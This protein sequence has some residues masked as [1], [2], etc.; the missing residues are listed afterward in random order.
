MPPALA[1]TLIS[2][3]V[4]LLYRGNLAP[5]MRGATFGALILILFNVGRLVAYEV[6]GGYQS[7]D[8]SNS[9]GAASSLP[10]GVEALPDIYYLIF[11]GYSSA[12]VL[13]E[14]H[15]FDNSEFIRSL[16]RKGFYIPPDARSNY[17]TTPLS[18]AS[19][20]RMKYLHPSIPTLYRIDDNEVLNFVKSVGYQYI[21]LDSGH[22]YTRRNPY[23]DIEVLDNNRLKLLLSDYALV[24]MDSTILPPIASQLHI[25]LGAPFATSG[26]K[27]FNENMRYLSQIPDMPGPTFTFNH[28][29]PPHPPY[30][31]DRHGNQPQDAAYQ[32]DPAKAVWPSKEYTD[33]I[34]YIN[35]SIE[36]L[37]DGI[38]E[39]SPTEPIIIIQ[40]DHGS[41]SL[42]N[43]PGSED[44][45]SLRAFERTGILNAYYLP[46]YCR[47]ALYPSITP[48]N[49]FRLVF[50]ACL[51]GDFDLLD[52]QSYWSRTATA[53][54]FSRI[55]Q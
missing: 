55:S 18:L 35:K 28:S 29:I 19:A 42:A 9:L 16:E 41:G 14:I 4:T 36:E 23:A 40:G 11:D 22:A 1:I 10:A 31:F 21:H 33:Q 44:A 50:D 24:L 15:G 32:F 48:V 25:N 17:T 27:R 46:E 54:D 52:D 43:S 8:S 3:S 51:G 20:L 6:D 37:V 45:P 49:T 30:V 13:Q 39:R 47:S 38:F 5:L 26:K 2:V 12:N 34:F 7:P 53:I